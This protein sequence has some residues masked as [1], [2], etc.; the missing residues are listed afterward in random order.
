[1]VFHG[2]TT[3]AGQEQGKGFAGIGKIL[4]INIK[5]KKAKF[6]Q[7]QIPAEI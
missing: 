1:M 2:P 5:I 6:I 7:A 4:H 3:K